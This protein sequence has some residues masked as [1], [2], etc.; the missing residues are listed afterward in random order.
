MTCLSVQTL[1][2]TFTKTW[3]ISSALCSLSM[4]ACPI[5]HQLGIDPD[6]AHSRTC[7]KPY[8][9]I[10]QSH[11]YPTCAESWNMSKHGFHHNYHNDAHRNEFTDNQHEIMMQ[12]YYNH[13]QDKM[14]P[15]Q[16]SEL[17]VKTF[18]YLSDDDVSLSMSDRI[19]L[20]KNWISTQI[21]FFLI[22]TSILLEIFFIP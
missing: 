14:T 12:D 17:K 5:N 8:N 13:N 20:E 1:L 2:H 9:H 11:D 18:P 3:M 10:P 6:I 7:Q 4:S 19:L 15:A 22:L 16:I 21:L